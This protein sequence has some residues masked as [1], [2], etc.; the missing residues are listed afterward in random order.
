M[1]KD[2]F[3]KRKFYLIL[4]CLLV[5]IFYTITANS[6]N[7]NLGAAMLSLPEGFSWLFQ[8]FIPTNASLGLLPVILKKLLE[9]ILLAVTATTTSAMLA[10]IL[11]ILGSNQTA[12]NPVVS[13]CVHGFAS[14]FR[15]MPVIVWAMILLL[16]FKQSQF[17]GYLAISFTSFGYLTRSFMETIDETAESTIEALKASGASYWQIIAQGVLPMVSASLLSWVLFLIENNIRDATLIGMVT[18]TGI[19]F[20]F[21]LYYKKFAYDVAGMVIL[22]LVITVISLELAATKIRRRIM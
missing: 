3:I 20:L 18:G 8:Q 15:N 10:L 5:M 13:L 4:F 9:T 11:A 7:F 19:G 21:D 6:I 16:S 12:V 17:T 14:F 22:V 1:K 2:I